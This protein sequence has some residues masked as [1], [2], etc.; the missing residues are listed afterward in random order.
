MK[1]IAIAGAGEIGAF[2]AERLAAEKFDVTVIDRDREALA[3][4]QSTLDVAGVLGS[5]TNL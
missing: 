2:I 5:A 1:K 4:V 3:N